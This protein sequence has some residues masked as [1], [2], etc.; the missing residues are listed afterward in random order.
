MLFYNNNYHF[1]VL[2]DSGN[3][4]VYISPRSENELTSYFLKYVPEF[5][6][7][8]PDLFDKHRLTPIVVGARVRVVSNILGMDG[9]KGF[10]TEKDENS[11][12]VD[13][14]NVG[15]IWFPYQTVTETGSNSSCSSSSR[16]SSSSSNSSSSSSSCSS[17]SSSSCS[18]SRSSSS[19][20]CSKS[21]SSSSNSSSSSSS[22]S[23]LS[24]SSSSCSRSSS[25]SSC[26]S[27]SS[28][29]CSK[30][31]SSC[32]RSSSSSSRSSSSSSS[33][34]SLSSSSCSQSSS[35][36]SCSRSSSSSSKSSSSSSSCSS[37]SSSSCSQSSS[38]KSSSS[39]SSCSSLSSSSCSQ[40]SSSKSSSNSSSLSSS[41]SSSSNSA[42]SSSSSSSSSHSSSS[43]SSSSK[44]I[45][46]PLTAMLLHNDNGS[47][48]DATGRHTMTEGGF[49]GDVTLVSGKFGSAAQFNLDSGVAPSTHLFCNGINNP[50]DFEFGTS[51]FTIDFWV[52][53]ATFGTVGAPGPYGYYQH[54][55]GYNSFSGYFWYLHME[56][57]TKIFYCTSSYG[58]VTANYRWNASSII[59]NTN[60]WYHVA[61]Q[62]VGT[63]LYLAV[64]GNQRTPTVLTAIGSNVFCGKHPS[65]SLNNDRYWLSAKLQYGQSVAQN[66]GITG[67]RMDEYR[68]LRNQAYWGS[69]NFTPPSS[70]YT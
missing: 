16:S 54:L 1:L 41:S 45:E 69:S 9:S 60:T 3:F 4:P 29:S 34:S 56:S 33:C 47:W 21:S 32:S 39:S 46:P 13:I 12:R 49:N 22:C 23:S 50:A 68:L 57:S 70:P 20:S 17:M 38:S 18:S 8:E 62:R 28:S 59:T 30:S 55:T 42:K 26:S 15:Q 27:L 53:F 43:L 61:L 44:Y 19:S 58:S 67:G 25:S 63:S 51:D 35:S 24:S 14:D 2:L 5:L 11:Y 6:S 37:L 40:S 31:S 36:S 65:S 48:P 7:L 64:N 52:N 66:N 10:V